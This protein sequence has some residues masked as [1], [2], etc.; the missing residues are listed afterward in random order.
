MNPSASPG[1]P[2]PPPLS[3]SLQQF[4]RHVKLENLI[5]GLSGGVLSTLVLHPLD[6]VK[7]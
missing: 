4:F 3:S 1:A 2:T 5:A 6:L 7:I